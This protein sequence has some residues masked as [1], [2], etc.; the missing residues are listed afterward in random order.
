MKLILVL[1]LIVPTLS[2]AEK[3]MTAKDMSMLGKIDEN[4]IKNAGPNKPVDQA[5][6]AT[7]GSKFSVSCKDTSGKEFKTGEAGYEDCLNQLR[8]KGSVKKDNKDGNSANLN[9]KIGE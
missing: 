7:A 5:P 8:M 4:A 1:I 6:A 3:K 2:W 9:F